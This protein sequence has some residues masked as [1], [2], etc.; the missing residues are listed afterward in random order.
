VW[1]PAVRLVST[2]L[3]LSQL[4]LQLQPRGR[5]CCRDGIQH[6]RCPAGRPAGE[7]DRVNPR[8]VWFRA[9]LGSLIPLGE[10]DPRSPAS[11]LI[12]AAPAARF[13]QRQQSFCSKG[14][15]Q[16]RRRQGCG[17]GGAALPSSA[18][19]RSVPKRSICSRCIRCPICRAG[20][21]PR[22]GRSVRRQQGAD[23]GSGSCRTACAHLVG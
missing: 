10:A 19:W 11:G 4:S 17:W 23:S 15:A 20:G 18:A 5:P 2:P 22:Q 1:G 9:G 13:P 21:A 7:A 12:P 8:A 3:A 16:N 6:A 14:S